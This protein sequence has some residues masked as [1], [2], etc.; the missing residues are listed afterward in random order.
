MTEAILTLLVVGAIG[1]LVY[2]F[3]FMDDGR[4]P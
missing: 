2:A 1:L 4:W 3:L